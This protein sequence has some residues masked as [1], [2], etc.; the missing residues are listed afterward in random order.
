MAQ[1]VSRLHRLHERRDALTIQT[2][3][4]THVEM[5]KHYGSAGSLR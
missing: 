1:S 5:A 3:P 2:Q 4:H